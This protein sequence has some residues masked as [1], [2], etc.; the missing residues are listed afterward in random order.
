E[1]ERTV[2]GEVSPSVLE[3]LVGPLQRASNGM[4]HPSLLGKTL[5]WQSEDSSKTRTL[6]VTVSVGRGETRLS[7]EERYGNLAGALF[8]GIRGGGGTGLGLGVGMGVGLGALGSP[9]F[10]ILFPIGVMGGAWAL[11][12][13][14]FRNSVYG[15]MRILTKLMN[16]MVATV[17]DGLEGDS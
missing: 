15:R 1:L 6:Q 7:I 16:E 3:R 13:G 5:T 8:G 12:R 10:A 11:A 4:G 9:L 14:I 2:R 17:E